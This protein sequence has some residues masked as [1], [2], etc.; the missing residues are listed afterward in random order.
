MPEMRKVAGRP[1]FGA[2][3]REFRLAAGLSQ[4]IL[5]ERAAMSADGISALE[6]GINKAP[7]RETLALLLGA[8][9]LEAQQRE[10]IEA[11]AM[12]PA[13]PRASRTRASRKRNLPKFL[14]PLFGRETELAE[15]ERLVASSHIV[16]V[17]GAGGVG[18]T[19]LAAETGS[20]AALTDC[21]DGTW[22]VDLAPAHDAGGVA[23]AIAAT[24]GIR[25]RP[26]TTLLDSVAD[27]L[28]RKSALLILDN[29]EQ[30]V[31]AVAAAVQ[32]I[33]A[34]CPDVRILATSR[35]P[36]EVPGEQTYRLASLNLEASVTLFNESARR[37]DPSFA[38]DEDRLT[39]E[40]ICSRLDGIALAIELAAA[41]VR[42]LSVTQIEER[43][44]ERFGV[45]SGGGRL[46]RHQ[47][48]RAL[49]DWSYDLLSREDQTLFTRLAVFPAEFSLEAALGDL[50]PDEGLPKRRFSSCLDLW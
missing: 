36:L 30:V 16:T 2:L 7:Q 34:G 47:T 18:K 5:A 39:I 35:Q 28:V 21:E 1:S 50:L 15:V 27:A 9:Q 48:M 23:S 41:R 43:L 31:T 33:L 45:L 10:A 26:D 19:R 32:I 12:R 22:F 13:R 46:A 14:M 44:S 24:L 17:I 40:R 3:L 25:E 4:E 11:A 8:L 29:C 38:P 20:S 49:V 37:A 42:L 6:R